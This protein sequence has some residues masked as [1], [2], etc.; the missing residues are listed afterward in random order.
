MAEYGLPVQ[1]QQFHGWDPLKVWVEEAHKNDMRVHVWFQTFF[2]GNRTVSPEPY[3]PI[4]QKYPDWANVERLTVGVNHPMPS[5][6]ETGHFFLDPANPQVRGYLSKLIQEI[7][8]QYPVD[9][10]NLDYIRYPASHPVKNSTFLSTTWGYSPYARQTFKALIDE[11]RKVAEAKAIEDGKL[12]AQKVGKPY[13]PPVKDPKAL[14]PK[15][16]PVELTYADPLWT[17]WVLW[18]KEQVSRFVQDV[19][20]KAH[21]MN[22]KLM[23]SAVV[24]HQSQPLNQLKL[25]DWPRWV[26]SGWLDALTP[27]GLGPDSEGVYRDS[28]EFNRVVQGKVP[29]Y[30]GIF[31]MYNRTSPVEFLS[32]IQS[33]QKARMPGVVLFERSRLD[34][35]YT[36]ALLEGAFRE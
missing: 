35:D 28:M 33:A 25:Q 4:L 22:P 15:S 32:Q 36:E 17:R 26:Q 21:A 23:V 11:E 30:V 2:A 5:N 16:D 19:T 10:F 6:V 34:S 1:H 8:T 20:Q 14:P 18:R 7:L 9:G 29:V 12:A 31:G 24:F 13:V 3:G 27:I